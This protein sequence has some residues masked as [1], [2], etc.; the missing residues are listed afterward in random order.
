MK[1]LASW[2]IAILAAM[3]GSAAAD[4]PA[5]LSLAEAV[6]RALTANPSLAAARLGLGAAG[7]GVDF[8][9]ARPDPDLLLEQSRETPH[10]AASLDLSIE[11][12]GKRRRRVDLANAEL[13]GAVATV[14][15][16]EMETR[17]QV[18]RSYYALVA[19]RERFAV[20]RQRLELA[21]RALAAARARFEAGD[22]P[23]LEVLQ[24]ELATA[25]AKGE[26][27]DRGAALDA[28]TASLVILLGGPPGEALAVSGELGDGAVPDPAALA[29]RALAASTELALADQRIAEGEARVALARAGK[30]P[31][32][33]LS[34]GATHGSQPEFDYGWRGALGLTLPISGRHRAEIEVERQ[35]LAQLEAERE[36]LAARIRGEVAAAAALAAAHRQRYERYRGEVLPAA[37]E[38][39][40]LAEESYRAGKTGLVS[41]LQSLSATGETRQRAIEAGYDY[42]TALADL[43]L[44]LG[45]PL[46]PPP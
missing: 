22:V 4:G 8:A 18:R 44:A 24:T 37:A 43:E 40:S 26:T 9:A 21:E 7:A 13:E 29:E 36:A 10:D 38:I 31:D 19:A 33:T 16:L 14:R 6:A 25:E 35:R 45:A 2:A 3:S 12:G 34:V 39:E 5:P 20:S 46:T 28:A 23:R 15:A 17:N 30:V 32:V 11:T 41:L 1:A 42:Q 27:E